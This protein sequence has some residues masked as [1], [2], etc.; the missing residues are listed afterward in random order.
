V[1]T[2]TDSG[3][4][5]GWLPTKGKAEV[6]PCAP[7]GEMDGGTAS[8]VIR[9]VGP[10]G[11]GGSVGSIEKTEPRLIEAGGKPLSCQ[12][13]GNMTFR[14]RDAVLHGALASFVSL[15]WLSPKCVCYICASCGFVHWFMPKESGKP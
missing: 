6:L 8:Q 4:A 13:C 11:R 14:Q 15:E 12:V 3:L 10:T 9:S 7:A 1:P 5:A 2:T